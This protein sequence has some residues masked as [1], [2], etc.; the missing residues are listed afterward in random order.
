VLLT[1]SR[2]HFLVDRR[3]P[4]TALLSMGHAEM[5]GSDFCLSVLTFSLIDCIIED[6]II[7][8]NFYLDPSI[9][10]P[11]NR[12]PDILIVFFDSRSQT[13]TFTLVCDVSSKRNGNI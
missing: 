10:R 12:W 6:L 8:F 3:L 11:R 4:G 5:D 13:L 9:H 7:L 2:R 1:T